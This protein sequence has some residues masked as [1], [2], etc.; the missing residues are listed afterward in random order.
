M[1]EGRRKCVDEIEG[2]EVT[3]LQNGGKR[4]MWRQYGKEKDNMVS[5]S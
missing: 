3:C 1:A 5:I 4:V 2:K